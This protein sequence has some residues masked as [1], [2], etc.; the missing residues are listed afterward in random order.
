MRVRIE[1]TDPGYTKSANYTAIAGKID[2]DGKYAKIKENSCGPTTI[3]FLT[4]NPN[5]NEGLSTSYAGPTIA[6]VEAFA[7]EDAYVRGGSPGSI[8]ITNL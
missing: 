1:N 5:T 2:Y 4:R 7:G 8:T 3:S 6:K